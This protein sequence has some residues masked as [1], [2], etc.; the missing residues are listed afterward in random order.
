MQ[1]FFLS[2]FHFQRYFMMH[3][4]YAVWTAFFSIATA[5]SSSESLDDPNTV[6]DGLGDEGNLDRSLNDGWTIATNPSIEEQSSVLTGETACSGDSSAKFRKR[7]LIPTAPWISFNRECPNPSNHGVDQ[8][9]APAPDPE[10]K[11]SSMPTCRP[12]YTP[13]CCWKHPNAK[14]QR[15]RAAMMDYKIVEQC[16]P[17][18]FSLFAATDV[19]LANLYLFAVFSAMALLLTWI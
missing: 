14:P 3:F 5:N 2:V 17:C 11:T 18:K 6:L 1:I 12:G 13:G 19:Y 10:P 8:Q 7:D 16:E 9:P 15:R 4:Y